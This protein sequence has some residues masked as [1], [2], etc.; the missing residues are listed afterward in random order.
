MGNHKRRDTVWRSEP[1]QFDDYEYDK[2]IRQKN[3]DL[4]N[5]EA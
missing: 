2:T 3:S 5:L 1:Y 4:R